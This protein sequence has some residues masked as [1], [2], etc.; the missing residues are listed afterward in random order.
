M[1]KGIGFII[2][3]FAL[4][5]ASQT[6]AQAQNKFGHIDFGKLYELVLTPHMDSINGVLQKYQKDLELIL[7]EMSSEYEKKA[8]EYQANSSGYSDLIKQTKEGEIKTLEQKI[9]EFQTKAQQDIQAKQMELQN[10][11]IEKA[12]GAVEKVA[13]A[14]GYTYILNSTEGLLLY[15]EPSQDIMS[16]VKKELGL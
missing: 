5:F 1:K 6:N 8:M 13:K 16:L 2:L 9:Y 15:A 11:F 12:K 10:P 3:T 4:L 7:Q 14:N